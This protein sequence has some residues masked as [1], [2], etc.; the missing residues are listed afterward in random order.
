MNTIILAA[1]EGRRL[2]PLTLERPKAMLNVGGRTLIERALDGLQNAG[3]SMTDIIILSGHKSAL[4]EAAAPECTFIHNKI[5]DSTNNI[6][7]LWLARERLAGEE[8][9]LL[10]SDVLFSKKMAV[11]VLSDDRES[12]LV[13]DDV[14]PLVTEEM[15]VKVDGKGRITEI[16]KTL[17]VEESAGEYIGLARFGRD[18]SKALFERIGEMVSTDQTDVWY[19]NAINDILDTFPLYSLSTRGMPWIE[20]DDHGDLDRASEIAKKIDDLE[21]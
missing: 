10:N 9:I 13:V 4:L 1:G 7:S 21:G 14:S 19:E 18:F 20:I 15:R 8:F 12:V 5:Y 3:I 16:A 2:H 17:D 6:Y 11:D